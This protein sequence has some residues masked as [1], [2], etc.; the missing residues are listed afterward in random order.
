MFLLLKYIAHL[1]MWS[2]ECKT[3]STLVDIFSEGYI[4][5]GQMRRL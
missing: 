4:L 1:R 5:I 2:D 3:F